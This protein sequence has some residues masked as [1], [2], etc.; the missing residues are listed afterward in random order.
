M[1][2]LVLGL[3]LL[4]AS[5]LP[6]GS[7][8]EPVKFPH[9]PDRLHAFVWRNWQTVPPER[10]A[11]AIGATKADIVALGK[12]MGLP[13][14]PAVSADQWQRLSTTIIKHNW[15]LLP[16]EQLLTLLDW[17]PE[18]LEYH[19]QEDDFLYIKLGLLKPKC[20][21]I[22]W[23][24][25]DDAAR[26]RA[27]QIAG[28]VAQMPGGLRDLGVRPFAFLEELTK[29]PAT[30][31]APVQSK[32][33]PRYCFS[34]FGL[35]G[36]PFLGN[37]D[38]IYP[39]GYLAQMAAAGV[40]GVWLQG[41][42]YTLAPFPWE[43]AMSERY[44][45]RLE[46]LR[47]LVARAAKYGLGIYLYL[48]E[49]RKMHLSFFEKH[50]E[51]K[52]VT[53]G[54]YATMCTSHPD[55]QRYIA[56][57][58]ASICRAV[59]GLKGFFSITASENLT[60]CCSHFQ[61]AQCP[62]CSKREPAEVVAELINLYRQG[63]RQ[64]GSNADLL[65]WDWGWPDEWPA[66]LIPLLQPDTSLISVSEWSIPI[67]RGG[68]KGTV[69]EYSMSVIGPGP[70][71]T[72]NWGLARDHGMRAVAKVQVGAT[73]ELGSVPYIPVLYNVAAHMSNLRGAGVDGLML[74]W[75]L[76]GYPSP[77]LEVA[78]ELGRATEDGAALSPEDA[79]QRVAA[80]RFGAELGPKV[81]AAWKLWSEAFMEFPYNGAVLYNAP[82]H[83]GPSN[84]LWAQPT[85]YHATMVGFPYD[86]ID[87]WRG[88]YPPD[89][90]AQQFEKVAN[91]FQ[92]GVDALRAQVATLK[93]YD[94]AQLTAVH[95]ELDVADACAIHYQS[96]ANQARFVLARKA[97]EKTAMR[98]LIES[99]RDL[100]ARLY[101]LQARDSRLGYEASNQY[102]YLTLDLAEKIL[103][104]EYLLAE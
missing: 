45:E 90:L 97:G 98:A 25:P 61:Q 84:L 12:A 87:G 20:E 69:G 13:E 28:A 36:D 6:Q 93:D 10:M 43:P 49:P 56:E 79:V 91:G 40:D 74:S 39:E 64:A 55:V 26:A 82:Q 72:R 89:I 53:E 15:H 38:A 62:R 4:A 76:G 80:R 57:S 77:N 41:V 88:S 37:I 66:K 75:T 19:L 85:G 11:A 70:R 58:M 51:L 48:N 30:P 104:C 99:E 18:M 27:A 86:D 9:F 50:P 94:A 95:R 60:N 8:P 29:A 68:V 32:F 23:K 31:P 73:W 92:S 101:V 35:T 46:N 1:T 102:Y 24:T 21:P 44:E 14:P 17:T 33:S 7:A 5:P 16:Y 81:A 22:I 78:A 54:E 47:A 67:E 52:G 63:I 59:P 2:P 100:A 65:S 83:V 103:N 96:A 71:A 34:Y 3:L 42:L